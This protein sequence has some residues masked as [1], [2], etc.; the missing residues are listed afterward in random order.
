MPIFCEEETDNKG[1][2]VEEGEGGALDDG[3]G[4]GDV[5][6]GVGPVGGQVEVAF[7]IGEGGDQLEETQEAQDGAEDGVDSSVEGQV[8][9][10]VG[11]LV[12]ESVHGNSN[13]RFKYTGKNGLLPENK[14]REVGR[15]IE[16]KLGIMWIIE[17]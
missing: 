5:D 6:V 8:Q 14:K 11:Q 3:E 16:R 17:V 9:E 10:T 7:W 13:W 1:S 12:L 4:S 15:Q 2:Y